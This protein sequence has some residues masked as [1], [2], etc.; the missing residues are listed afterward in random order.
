TDS[1]TLRKTNDTPYF[2]HVSTLSE[3]KQ[4][5][6][7]GD[8]KTYHFNMLRSILEKT[9]SFF[10]FDRFGKCIHGV[11]DE[12]LFERALNLL[13]HGKY[14]VYEPEEMNQDNK[15]LFKKILAGFL[16]KY[17][18]DLPVLLTQVVEEQEEIPKTLEEAMD[19]QIEKTAKPLIE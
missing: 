12:V 8:I 14:S 17:Q 2:H 16:D 7:S 18:F 15:D 4:V 11:D 1:Y 13:S 6:E 3:L 10:G 19:V 5:S 9:A